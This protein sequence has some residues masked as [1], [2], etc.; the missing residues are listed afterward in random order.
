MRKEHEK[1]TTVTAAITKHFRALKT[2]GE[3]AMAQLDDKDLH[4]KH[5][6][7]D[8]SV[9][10][11]VAHLHGN[12]LSR[13]TDFM[14]SDGEKVWRNRDGEF[15]EASATGEQARGLWEEG[16]DCLFR[17]LGPLSD[18]DLSRMVTVR[19]EPHSVADALLRQLAHYAGH[20][21]QIIYLA[22]T[23]KGAAWK[24]ISIPR[25]ASSA[26]EETKKTV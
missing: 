2:Q 23:I 17:A 22:K 15:E 5:D 9:F 8:N 18:A 11:L 6:A 20:I 21:G 19:G 3:K 16:W 1:T 25:A 4:W 14:E 13:F 26:G 10:V 12:M 7:G 24:T